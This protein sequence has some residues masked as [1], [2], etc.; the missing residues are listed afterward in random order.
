[1]N[2]RTRKIYITSNTE[3]K[4]KAKAEALGFS[5]RGWL[6]HYLTKV[7]ECEFLILDENTKSILKLLL[8]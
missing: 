6:S 4:L 7:A 1:M 5:G 2:K 3:S 8:T